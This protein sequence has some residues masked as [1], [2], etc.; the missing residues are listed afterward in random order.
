[1]FA[2]HNSASLGTKKPTLPLS[3]RLF[4]HYRQSFAACLHAAT[5]LVLTKRTRSAK[6]STGSRS[7]QDSLCGRWTGNLLQAKTCSFPILGR[8]QKGH[9]GSSSTSDCVLDTQCEGKAPVIVTKDQI[10]KWYHIGLDHITVLRKRK[11][12]RWWV[13]QATLTLWVVSHNALCS[14]NH[15]ASCL[16][17]WGSKFWVFQRCTARFTSLSSPWRS[18]CATP[19]VSRKSF[20]MPKNC[21]DSWVWESH[22]DPY[23]DQRSPD[24]SCRF[25]VDWE[26]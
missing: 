18:S 14:W 13:S 11:S 21:A 7:N 23:S 5:R 22:V 25:Q 8:K 2:S 1:M 3:W 26:T 10:L 15:L 6:D 4:L 12:R 16:W 17:K 20:S 24:W 19:G 9:L